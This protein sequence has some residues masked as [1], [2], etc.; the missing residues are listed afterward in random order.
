M[1]QEVWFP[2]VINARSKVIIVANEAGIGGD[3][4]DG[5]ADPDSSPTNKLSLHTNLVDPVEELFREWIDKADDEIENDKSD[6]HDKS[7][8]M[9]Y[10]LDENNRLA[11]NT[12]ATDHTELPVY[13]QDDFPFSFHEMSFDD[14]QNQVGNPVVAIVGES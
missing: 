1:S 6:V 9:S 10:P 14:G 2:G 5:P 11:D 3:Y 7:L 13:N 12:G 8:E 4:L